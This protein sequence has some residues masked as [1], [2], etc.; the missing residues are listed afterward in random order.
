MVSSMLLSL[1]LFSLSGCGASPTPMGNR[2]TT[3]QNTQNVVYT[4]HGKISGRA[5]SSG[6]ESVTY[7]TSMSSSNPNKRPFHWPHFWRGTSTIYNSPTNIVPPYQNAPDTLPNQ[8]NDVPNSG[9]NS[10]SP[11]PTP[12][13]NYTPPATNNGGMT[14]TQPNKAGTQPNIG[15]TKP[16]TGALQPNTSQS[17]SGTTQSTKKPAHLTQNSSANQATSQMD[18]LSSQV[19]QL[20]NNARKNNGL[21][22][23]KVDPAL[24]KMANMK[25]QDMLNNNYFSHTSPTYGSPFDMMNKLGISYTAAG[26]NIAEGQTSATKVMTD[27]MNSPGHRANILNKQYTYIGVGHTSNK[28]FWVQE[29]IKK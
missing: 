11:T 24:V 25:A 14:Q 18:S 2:N 4:K 27:W 5:V 28:N 1:S 10:V 13:P 8:T 12:T 21:S 22:P 26:E 7:N 19:I 15:A 9:T 16:N 6:Q 29:F 3:Q 17:N 23:L 20:V